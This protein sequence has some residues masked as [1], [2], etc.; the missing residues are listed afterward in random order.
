MGLLA[1]LR[2]PI[3]LFALKWDIGSSRGDLRRS[4]PV[5]A[6]CLPPSQPS[7]ASYPLPPLPQI[8]LPLAS[9]AGTPASLLL[10]LRPSIHWCHEHALW[11]VHNMLSWWYM[12]TT[13]VV[14]FKVGS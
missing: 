14:A 9:T 3:G 2:S 8:S 10:A 6:P 7:Y 12:P 5:E 11:H 1:D 13:C 4:H